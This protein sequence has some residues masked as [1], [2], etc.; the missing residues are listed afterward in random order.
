MDRNDQLPQRRIEIRGTPEQTRRAQEYISQM[1]AEVQ[2]C[3][4]FGYLFVCMLHVV[5]LVGC[6]LFLLLILYP[7]LQRQAKN[8][9]QLYDLW[10]GDGYGYAGTA[11]GLR[12]ALQI[13]AGGPH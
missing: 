11:T 8:R 12:G 5:C 4:I 3:L 1:I 10:A 2:C 7:S 13:A 9:V 6:M